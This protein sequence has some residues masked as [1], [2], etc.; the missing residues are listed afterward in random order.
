MDIWR[1]GFVRM[2]LHEV[3]ARGGI[4]GLPTDWLPGD[5][6][7]F[8]FLADP[9]GL[10]RDGKFYLFVEA[11][12]YRDRQGR[13]EVLTYDAGFNLLDRDICLSEPWH[14]SY[15]YVFEADSQTYMLPEAHR[16]GGLTLYRAVDFPRRWEAVGQ[17]ELPEVAVD[18][19]PLHHN[20][21][22]WL[23]YS[24][25][26][27]P[28]GAL[29]LAFARHVEGPWKPHPSNPIRTGASGARPGG[30]PVVVDGHVV[31]PVQ[32]CT[33]TYGE[34][35]RLLR[36]D[37]L[38]TAHVASSLGDPIRPPA[39]FAPY[40]AGL[41]TLSACGPITLFDVKRIDR[42]LAGKVIGLRGKARRAV[43]KFRRRFGEKSRG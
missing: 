17:I 19:T 30:T 14:L 4:K 16:S 35:V 21:L 15:P 39:S 37:E 9:F 5:G 23:F 36:F 34:A 29:H 26:N 24:P 1:A 13:V 12:D 43:A 28:E 2:P 42:S 41:H 31:L 8:T 7:R 25:A 3:L 11:L 33:A 6:R 18:A 38:S 27:P 22:W 10:E 20:G 40:D 32:D